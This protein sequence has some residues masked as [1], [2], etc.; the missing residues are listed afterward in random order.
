MR[1]AGH[2]ASC[3]R[4]SWREVLGVRPG[5]RVTLDVLEGIRPCARHDRD[6]PGRRHDGAR[7]VHGPRRA[8]PADARGRCRVGRAAAGRPRERRRGCRERSSGCRPSPGPASS[9]PCCNSFRDTMAANMNL[10]ICDQP[11]LRRR[12]RFRRRLQRRPRVAVRAQPRAGEPARARLHARARFRSILLGELALL[13]LAA[14]PVGGVLGYGL[15]SLIVGTIQSEVYRFPLFVSASGCRVVVSRHH[16]PP[17]RCRRC[18]CAAGWTRS[19][20]LPS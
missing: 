2:P 15:S 16:R 4:R 7:D 5:D 18:S 10:S 13:T 8:A 11:D 9:A 6:R 14:L 17:R 20:W 3:C 12:H 1:D 19:I